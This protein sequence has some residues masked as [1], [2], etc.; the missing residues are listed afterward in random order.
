HQTRGEEAEDPFDRG[1]TARELERGDPLIAQTGDIA[2]DRDG[3]SSQVEVE[4][5][6]RELVG[7]GAVLQVRIDAQIQ[8]F[9]QRSTGQMDAQV[10]GAR[11]SGKLEVA[12]SGRGR[13]EARFDAGQVE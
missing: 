13:F 8:P 3:Q 12:G 6:D 7:G 2:G 11:V 1:R 10:G 9:S 4:L 5:R